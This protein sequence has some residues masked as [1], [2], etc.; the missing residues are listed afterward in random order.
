MVHRY[1]GMLLS[2]ETER[3]NDIGSSLDRPRKYHTINTFQREKTNNLRYHV[4]VES[5][6]SDQR[7]N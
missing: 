1:N 2:H 3:D 5:V 7:T 6:S 4:Q